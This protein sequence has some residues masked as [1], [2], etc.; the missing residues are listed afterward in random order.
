[1]LNNLSPLQKK[2]SQHKPEVPDLLKDLKNVHFKTV[3]NSKS[4]PQ[5][6]KKLFPKTF[7]LP[8][9]QLVAGAGNHKSIKV[10][11]VFQGAQHQEGTTLSP[12]FATQELR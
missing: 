11:V 7:D 12:G 3:P 2:R 4:P 1:M 9:H 8:S 10:G 6:L 5:T